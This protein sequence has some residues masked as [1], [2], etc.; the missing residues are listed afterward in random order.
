MTEIDSVE[1]IDTTENKPKI[2]LEEASHEASHE[3][4][5]ENEQSRRDFDR[6][7]SNLAVSA[8]R[9]ITPTKMNIEAKSVSKLTEEEKNYLINLYKN[10]GED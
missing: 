6:S 4:S 8:Y 1:L 5:H 7:G 10:G 9:S 3:T 2:E